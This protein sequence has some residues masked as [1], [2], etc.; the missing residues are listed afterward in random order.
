MKIEKVEKLVANLHDK[1]EYVIHIRNLKQALNHGLVLEKVHRVIKFN[2]NVWLKSYINMNAD[3]KKKAKNSF[4]RDFFKLMNNAVFEKTM[5]NM[6]KHRYIKLVTTE[7]R[8]N[9]HVRKF[10]TEY[11]LAIEMKKTEIIM[12]KPVYLGFSLLELSKILMYKFWYD[13]V[14]PKYGKK[15]KFCYMDKDSFIV[16]IKTDDI[17]KHIAEDVETRFHTLNYQLDRPLP[18][19]KNKKVIGLMKNYA[20]ICWIKSKNL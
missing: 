13:Y 12:N 11:L 16:Y 7:G 1:T 17:Y 9:Y 14:K 3:L 18:K 15:A 19:E 4:E 10:F 20:K 6:R 5:E 8:R 2:E